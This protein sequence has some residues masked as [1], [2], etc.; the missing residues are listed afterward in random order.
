MPKTKMNPASSYLP[1]DLRHLPVVPL[2]VDRVCDLGRG[3][4]ECELS[5]FKPECP[6]NLRRG[7]V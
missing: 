3:V 1:H 4:S 7:G 5:G 2:G 6:A